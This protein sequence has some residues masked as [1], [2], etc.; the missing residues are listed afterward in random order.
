MF[1]RG[2][3]S[4]QIALLVFGCSLFSPTGAIDT[5]YKWTDEHG[6]THY[7]GQPPADRDYL[8]VDLTAGRLSFVESPGYE[9]LEPDDERNDVDGEPEAEPARPDPR[10]M[11][12]VRRAR[13]CEELGERLRWLLAGRADMLEGVYPEQQVLDVDSR[14]ELIEEVSAEIDEHC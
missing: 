8:I 10:T 2:F 7:A 4:L 14:G 5:L 1:S 3:T 6:T 13:Y 12:P 11:D 9:Q